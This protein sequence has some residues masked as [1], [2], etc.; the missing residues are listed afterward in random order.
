MSFIPLRV[1]PGTDLRA[2][3][4]SYSSHEGQGSGFV[5][6]GLG[7][8]QDARLRFAAQEQES[9]VAGPSELLAI[10]G[11][12]SPS[13]CHVHV[14]VATATGHV[15]GGHLCYGSTVRTTVELLVA[16]TEGYVLS[17]ARDPGT[18]YQ[19]LVVTPLSPPS[20]SAA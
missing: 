18:G 5:V 4:D 12:L 11:S 7:S 9:T 20:Q 2:F 13:G 15:L 8:L 10:S 6:A 14:A 17:R 19:E 1:P 3:L 16:L